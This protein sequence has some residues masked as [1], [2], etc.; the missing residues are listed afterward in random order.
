MTIKGGRTW[1]VALLSGALVMGTTACAGAGATNEPARLTPERVSFGYGTVDRRDVTGSIGSLTQEDLVEGRSMQL[2]D[3]LQSRIPGVRIVQ[4]PDGDLSLRI[5][6]ASN[7]MSGEPLIVVDGS[8]IFS[9]RIV[10][11]L[12]GFNTQQ[13]QRVDV[14]KDAGSTAMYGIHGGNGVIVIT[15]KRGR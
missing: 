15:T 6:G 8:P 2:L 11:V 5:R 14:L 1:A 7:S 10:G 13:I 9:N 4:R 3:L 12:Q